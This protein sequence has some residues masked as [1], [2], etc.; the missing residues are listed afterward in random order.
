MRQRKLDYCLSSPIPI[1]SSDSDLVVQLFG[2]HRDVDDVVLREHL[3]AVRLFPALGAEGLACYKMNNLLG[4]L[5]N[6]TYKC[7]S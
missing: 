6:Y 5:S 3:R 4:E 2:F 7:S 1:N